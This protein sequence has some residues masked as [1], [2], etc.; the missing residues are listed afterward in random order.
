MDC[1]FS[2]ITKDVSNIEVLN[3][4]P[5]GAEYDYLKPRGTITIEMDD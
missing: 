3:Y 1:I 5:P 2:K 4:T